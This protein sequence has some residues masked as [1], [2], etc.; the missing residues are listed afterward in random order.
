MRIT[1]THDITC[2]EQRFN[3]CE[4]RRAILN[5]DGHMLILGGPGSGKTTIALLKARR[6]VTRGLLDTQSVLFLS[7]SNSAV[8]R[9][10]ESAIDILRGE[11]GKKIEIK[12]YHSFS[13]DILHSHG[14]LLSQRRQLK[15]IPPYEAEIRRAGLDDAAW[16]REEGRLFIE[17]GLV[18]FDQFAPRTAELLNRCPR[19]LYIYANAYPYI[20]VDE[21]QDTDKAQW[22]II[23][24]LSAKCNIMALGDPNQRIYD[25]RPGVSPRGLTNSANSLVLKFITLLMRTIVVPEPA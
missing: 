22:D 5:D 16:R 6:I 8:R 18:T 12:T 19:L 23:K 7:F 11:V 2:I 13:W 14:Y 15:I 4:K 17:E 3:L 24:V 9:I 21:F 1:L 20:I 10:A 25:F